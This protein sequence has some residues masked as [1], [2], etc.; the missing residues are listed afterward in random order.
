ML[1]VPDQIHAVD[2]ALRAGQVSCPC[3]AELRPWGWAR[4]RV[5][6][7]GDT[8]RV[9]RPRRARCRA[10]ALT[11]V[12]LPAVMLQRR[13][14]AIDVIG[15][16]LLDAAHGHG[17]RPIAVRLGVPAG[18]VRGWLRRFRARACALAALGTRL[19]YRLDA[20][21]GRLEPA[22]GWPSPVH[23]A[24]GEL[25]IATAAYQRH[26]LDAPT[27]RWQALCTLTRGLLLANTS[28]PCPPVR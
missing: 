26:H 24:L 2:R 18:T 25:A 4:R 6:R 7:A 23:A 22:G 28:R 8:V 9:I 11:H 10:C 3:S 17:H 5:L 20:S 15:A 21:L 14:Y 19:A 16:A 27:D 13:A 12:L 1:V